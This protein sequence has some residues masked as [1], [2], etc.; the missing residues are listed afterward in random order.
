MR[1]TFKYAFKFCYSLFDV[2]SVDQVDGDAGDTSSVISHVTNAS[3]ILP[4][5]ES[6]NNLSSKVKTKLSG[7]LGYISGA[8]APSQSSSVG[9]L[10]QV[11]HLN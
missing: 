7:A 1:F 3:S 11:S 8:Q 6:I 2:P 10:S 9:D 5:S 4:T